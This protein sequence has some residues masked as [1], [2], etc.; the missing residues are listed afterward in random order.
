M[1]N[2][3]TFLPMSLSKLRTELPPKLKRQTEKNLETYETAKFMSR[4][5]RKF[6][7]NATGFGTI[8]RTLMTRREIPVFVI[9]II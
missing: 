4:D 9:P 3:L 7:Q 2:I 6:G 8:E 5:P 1:A